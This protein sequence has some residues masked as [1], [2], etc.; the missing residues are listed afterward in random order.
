MEDTQNDEEKKDGEEQKD[1]A[2]DQEDEKETPQ[3]KFEREIS[4]LEPA[5][6]KLYREA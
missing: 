3:A 6:H 2:D 4:A 5:Y 1:E